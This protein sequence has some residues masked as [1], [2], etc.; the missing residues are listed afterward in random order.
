MTEWNLWL[1]ESQ[2]VDLLPHNLDFVSHNP[3]D[4]RRVVAAEAKTVDPDKQYFWLFHNLYLLSY[5]FDLVTQYSQISHKSDLNF[6]KY[7]SVS[8]SSDF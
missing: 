2:N 8:H 1:L 7:S 5:I 3:P 4:I 6:H